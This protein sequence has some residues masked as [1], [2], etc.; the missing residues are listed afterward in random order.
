MIIYTDCLGRLLLRKPRKPGYFTSARR[1]AG[2]LTLACEVA[3]RLLYSRKWNIWTNWRGNRVVDKVSFVTWLVNQTNDL[4]CK[5]WLYQRTESNVRSSCDKFNNVCHPWSDIQ[6]FNFNS[7]YRHSGK[8]IVSTNAS[9]G[10]LE[11]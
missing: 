4:T 8:W 9:L 7:K 6:L 10:I 2:K 5:K 3:M 1:C 11:G